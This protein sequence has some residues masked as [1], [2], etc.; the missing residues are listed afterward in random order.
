MKRHET[1][2]DVNV[3]RILRIAIVFVVVAA[4]IHLGVWSMFVYYRNANAQRDLRQT[5][6]EPPR[7]IP[8]EPRLQVNPTEDWQTF[9]RQQQDLLNSYGWISRD[10][11]R[12][13]IPI[14]LAME[15]VVSDG[16][17]IP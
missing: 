3:H 12:V 8:P 4:A 9:R 10:E 5:L 17:R 11:R 7:P 15:K 14:E 1:T 2:S 13:H 6:I 16:G